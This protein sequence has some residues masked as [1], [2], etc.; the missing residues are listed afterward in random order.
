MALATVLDDAPTLLEQAVAVLRTWPPA[1]DLALAGVDDPADLPVGLADRAL[2]TVSEQVLGVPLEHSVACDRCGELT[3][4][5]LA[6]DDIPEHHPPGALT[7]PGS[8]VREPTWRDLLASGDDAVALLNRCTVTAGGTLEDLA[9]V[10][11]SL[12]GPLHAKCTGCGT[13]F[14]LD[15]DV[16][17]LVLRALGAVPADLDRDVHVLASR[18]GWDLAM[19]EAL[20]DHRRRRL[21]TLA[22]S[23]P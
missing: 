2:L 22:W 1:A 23:L 6:R 18:Y 4:L 21:A 11:G 3:T 5:T 15:V 20:P 8:R 14:E 19:I 12:S 16:I 17:E 13:H 9:R 7:G 10:E